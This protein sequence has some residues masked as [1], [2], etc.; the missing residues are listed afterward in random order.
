MVKIIKVIFF[1]SLF[2]FTFNLVSEDFS[3]IVQSNDDDVSELLQKALN[4]SILKVLGQRQSRWLSSD[5]A[6]TR[7]LLTMAQAMPLRSCEGIWKR[8]GHN[9]T[10]HHANTSV[11]LGDVGSS[12]HQ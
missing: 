6:P 11:L 4:Q 10:D 8:L 3:T 5:M 7:S 1:V 12:R 9:E 2:F